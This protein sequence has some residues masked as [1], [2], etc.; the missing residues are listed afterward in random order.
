MLLKFETIWKKMFKF[1][2]YL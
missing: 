2:D 1:V